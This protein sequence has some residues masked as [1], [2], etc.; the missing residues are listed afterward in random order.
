MIRLDKCRFIYLYIPEFSSPWSSYESPRSS[1]SEALP[2]FNQSSLTLPGAMPKTK[3]LAE[4]VDQLF[5]M[6]IASKFTTE[7]KKR[8]Y[9]IVNYYISDLTVAPIAICRPSGCDFR[10]HPLRA[11]SWVEGHPSH[12]SNQYARLMRPYKV[13][14]CHVALVLSN[15]CSEELVCESQI[16]YMYIY[17]LWR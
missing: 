12:V 3:S 16:I 7:P 5:P 6:P 15:S 4:S 17:I 8:L 9:T 14:T 1:V 10:V 2:F 13:E 11:G